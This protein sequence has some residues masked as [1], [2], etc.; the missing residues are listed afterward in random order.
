MDLKELIA[1]SRNTRGYENLKEI[2]G[3][4]LGTLLYKLVDEADKADKEL[5]IVHE[6]LAELYNSD[7]NTDRIKKALGDIEG[8]SVG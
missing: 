1:K 7:I 5:N 8:L 4:E 2:L 6:C 3:K